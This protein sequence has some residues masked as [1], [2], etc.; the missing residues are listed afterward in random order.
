MISLDVALVQSA[1]AF[2]SMALLGLVLKPG[3]QSTIIKRVLLLSPW[4]I[5]SLLL[6]CFIVRSSMAGFLALTNMYESL[7][8]VAF[9]IQLVQGALLVYRPV[10]ANYS[11][12]LLGA[13]GLAVAALLGASGLSANIVPLQP[14]LVSYWR[15]IHVPIIMLSYSLL[16]LSTIGAMAVL[17]K[18]AAP[19]EAQAVYDDWMATCVRL[20]FL[21]L[22]TGTILGA[23]WA[24]EAWGTYWNWD[25]KECMA[26][27]TVLIYGAYWHLRL[28][29]LVLLRAQAWLVLIG[30]WV[31]MLAYIG[32]NLMGVGLH[33]YGRF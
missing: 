19:E 22:I 31:L 14:A 6:G 24:N 9:G 3:G 18:P 4:W 28:H 25:P 15:A 5:A 32:V 10:F 1:L 26:L 23:V 2:S 29:E 17:L 16:L 8:A 27:A 30:F 33:S 11:G 20:G 12:L 13:Q 21:L 7:L